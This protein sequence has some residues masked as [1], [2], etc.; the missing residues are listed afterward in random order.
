MRAKSKIERKEKVRLP[1]YYASINL[2]QKHKTNSKKK[3]A[4][5]N[6]MEQERQERSPPRREGKKCSF[7]AQLHGMCQRDSRKVV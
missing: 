1:F 4:R 6:P 7:N 5:T 3:A 2:E